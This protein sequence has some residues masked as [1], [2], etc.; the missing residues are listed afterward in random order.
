MRIHEDPTW[1]DDWVNSV[2]NTGKMDPNK[3]KLHR[4]KMMKHARHTFLW[5]T[6]AGLWHQNFVKGGVNGGAKKSFAETFPAITSI[7]MS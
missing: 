7:T 6:V 1:I 2:I 4:E 3:I 5:S